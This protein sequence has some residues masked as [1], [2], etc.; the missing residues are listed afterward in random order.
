MAIQNDA[1]MFSGKL[2]QVHSACNENVFLP[3]GIPD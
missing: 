3:A 2:P 1:V